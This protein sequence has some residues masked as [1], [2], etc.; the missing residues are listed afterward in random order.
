MNLRHIVHIIYIYSFRFWNP[1]VLAHP[2]ACWYALLTLRW[3]R[4]YAMSEGFYGFLI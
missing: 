1:A 4:L 2:Y 3:R